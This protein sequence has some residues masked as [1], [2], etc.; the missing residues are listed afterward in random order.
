MIY[1]IDRFAQGY[2][3]CENDKR[4]SILIPLE[5]LPDTA[6]PSDCIRILADGSIILDEQETK[7]RKDRILKLQQRLFKRKND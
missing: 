1:S 6:K 7:R 5:K 3:I 2:A 4:E